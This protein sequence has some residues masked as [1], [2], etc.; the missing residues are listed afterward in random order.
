MDDKR[1]RTITG[2][3]VDL[4]K[5]SA[6]E[7]KFLAKILKEY[8]RAPEWSAFTRRWL[9][10]L[11]AAKLAKDSAVWRV[12]QDL[13]SRLGIEQGKVAPPDYRDH[14]ADLIEEKFGS[15]YRFCRDH[16]IDQSHLGKILAG[17]T[18]PSMA[19]LEKILGLLGAEVAVRS[20]ASARPSTSREASEELARA[21]GI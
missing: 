5:L 12:C 8:R 18:D 1:Y 11:F 3:R 6:E 20:K 2:R 10:D 15:R 19:F 7:K 14:L 4:G 13:D 21:L 9:G 16:G 17:K